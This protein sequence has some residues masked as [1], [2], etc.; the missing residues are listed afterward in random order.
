MHNDTYYERIHE[1]A[2]KDVRWNDGTRPLIDPVVIAAIA[3]GDKEKRVQCRKAF[4]E[5]VR[6]GV[7]HFDL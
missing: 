7:F 6:T 3:R 1:N 2:R 4:W 5:R